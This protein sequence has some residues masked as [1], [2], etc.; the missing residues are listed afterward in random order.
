M[1]I[2]SAQKI[3]FSITPRILYATVIIGFGA[4]IGG[5][6]LVLLLRYVQH[7]AYGYSPDVLM[8]SERFLAG[9]SAASSE[10]RLMVLTV[11][12]LI[13]GC[14][15]WVLYRYGRPLV[16]LGD[17]VKTDPARI[18]PFKTVCHALLQ[19]VTVAL[20]SPL[21]REV[22]PREF[23]AVFANWA[24]SKIGFTLNEV[25]VLVA[26]AAGAGLV[27]VYNVPLGGAIFAAEVLLC[28]FSGPVLLVALLSSLVAVVV[29]WVGLGNKP[30]YQIAYTGVSLSLVLW[31]IISGPFIGWVAYWFIRGTDLMRRQVK[32]N[33]QVPVLCLVNFFMIGV[34]AIY[35]PAILGNGRSPAQLEFNDAI[36]IELS[37]I[38]LLLRMFIICTTI[39]AGAHGGVLTPSL[40]NGALLAV[41][42]GGVWRLLGSDMSLSSFA[43][44]G[45]AAFLASA[46]KMPMTAVILVL[47]FTHVQLSFLLPILC[48]VI[49]AVK[50]FQ[51]CVRRYES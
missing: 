29:S 4:G 5:T 9:V 22:A 6:F 16:E 47:E 25:Q 41:V 35:F 1:I 50:M 28:D 45:A 37:L 42:L 27:A 7:L 2:L 8:S 12:G 20:G 10:R 51:G 43:I 23:S 19:I 14:G 21:G 3:V 44:V 15:W 11:C 18:P 38:L 32:H 34:L 33:W 31:S 17:A 48:A 39:R 26:C 40:A 36:G 24:V 13:A 30:E 49:G 46:Q